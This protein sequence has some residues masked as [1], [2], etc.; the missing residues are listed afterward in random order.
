MHK[1]NRCGA[2]FEGKTCPECGWK[3]ASS[4]RA[5]LSFAFFLPHL[6]P[7]EKRTERIGSLK[8]FSAFLFLI[9][10]VGLFLLFIAPVFELSGDKADVW[11]GYSLY[12]LLAGARETAEIVAFAPAL[13]VLLYGFLS[14]AAAIV[15]LVF[16]IKRKTGRLEPLFIALPYVFTLCG[17]LIGILFSALLP[18]KASS[19]L[20]LTEGGSVVSPFSTAI[21][22]ISLIAAAVLC[23]CDLL[24]L[25]AKYLDDYRYHTAKGEKL[26]ETAAQI[27][28]ISARG[29]FTMRNILKYITSAVCI[30]FFVV[31]LALCFLPGGV[32]AKLS[33]AKET[34][35][36]AETLTDTERQFEAQKIAQANAVAPAGTA[37]FVLLGIFLACAIAVFVYRL[38]KKDKKISSFFTAA[39]FVLY[40]LLVFFGLIFAMDLMSGA[41]FLCAVVIPTACVFGLCL[42]FELGKRYLQNSYDYLCL[43]ENDHA[44]EGDG[45]LIHFNVPAPAAKIGEYAFCDCG[46]MTSLILSDSV[47]AI[48]MSAFETCSELNRAVLGGV[49]EIGRYAFLDC[50][51][52]EEVYLPATLRKIDDYAFFHCYRLKSVIFAGSMADWNAVEK[53]KMW[54]KKIGKYCVHCSDGDLLSSD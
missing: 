51:A 22:A 30:L 49:I 3:A 28:N 12:G 1:C 42:L 40:G 32:L 17:A 2:E 34:L 19:G 33:E 16:R 8:F 18:A 23:V 25:H 48:G 7:R 53:G 26:T 46:K 6:T 29:T 35:A 37:A 14:L 31:Y 52:L 38:V 43:S 27:N 47:K 41:T 39:P 36:W 45:K 50:T 11:N 15:C 4:L 21:L 20:H 13:L 54:D 44:F 9:F 5:L 10:S 24:C